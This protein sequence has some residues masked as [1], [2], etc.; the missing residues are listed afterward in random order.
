MRRACLSAR[1]TLRMHQRAGV[2][3]SRRSRAPLPSA[4]H[5]ALLL[6]RCWLS[7]PH[8]PVG[9]L[10]ASLFFGGFSGS[11]DK[12]LLARKASSLM[13]LGMPSRMGSCAA[14][15]LLRRSGRRPR[16]GCGM[17]S[18]VTS[19][20]ATAPVDVAD[21]RARCAKIKSHIPVPATLHDLNQKVR[22]ADA[23]QAPSIMTLSCM[24]VSDQT[25]GR[26]CT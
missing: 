2:G 17:V 18:T 3:C 7:G 21:I 9:S 6:R 11:Q 25:R 20:E 4:P 22:A 14:A 16:F 15:V 19:V 1:R 13:R 26:R 12:L 5:F 8:S 24:E 23:A 10:P